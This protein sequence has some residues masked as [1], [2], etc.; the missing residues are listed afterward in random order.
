MNS[1]TYVISSADRTNNAPERV[2][3]DIPF[4]GFRIT[5]QNCLVEVISC[6]INGEVNVDLGYL[7]LTATGL[8]EDGLYCTN[9]IPSNE[10]VICTIPLNHLYITTGSTFTVKD[11]HIKKSVRF[12][13]KK[14]NF[15]SVVTDQDINLLD[16]TRFVL[17]LKITPF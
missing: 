11:C 9:S 15:V 10:A 14:L 5:Q 16:E 13:F 1:F 2:F 7:I 12:Q 4:G 8:A 17:T 6:F 3:Y